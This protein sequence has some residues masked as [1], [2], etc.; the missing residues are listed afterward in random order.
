VGKLVQRE[1]PNWAW[2]KEHTGKKQVQ[3]EEL[4]QMLGNVWW[5]KKLQRNTE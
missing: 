2:E 3:R 5:G 1:T 4:P